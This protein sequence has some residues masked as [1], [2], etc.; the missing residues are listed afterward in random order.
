MT[1]LDPQLRQQLSDLLKTGNAHMSF[2]DAVANFPENK[3]NHHPQNVD[4]SFWHLVEHL[5][6]TQ[7]DILDYLND[8]NYEEIAW[9]RDY[10]PAPD[11]TTDQAGWNASIV[12]FT[13]DRDQ[14]IAI[15]EN[16]ATDLT[17]P[18]PSSADHTILR[19]ILIVTDHNAYHIGE[20]GI[21][22]QVDNAWGAGHDE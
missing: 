16:P 12:A 1:A 20:L 14:L 19:E 3:I 17:A 21:L 5:R 8:P 10:W 15:V 18:V 2:E 6:I 11:A 22:R 4:Y 9:P 13:A 7:K